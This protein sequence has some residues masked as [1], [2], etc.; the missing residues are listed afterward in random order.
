MRKFKHFGAL[1]LLLILSVMLSACADKQARLGDMET[2]VYNHPS[3]GATLTLPAAWQKL[4]ETDEGAVFVNVDNS[5]SLGL[6]RELAGYSYYSAEGIAELAEELLADT[7]EDMEVL[8]REVLGKPDNAV[9]V[10][11]SGNLPDGAA[12]ANVAVISPLSAVRYFIVVTAESDVYAEQEQVL[13]DIF[14]S[15]ELNKTEDEIY[16]Q[17]PEN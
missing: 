7:L 15:F 14:A 8:Q 17:I 3:N 10:T 6:V 16:E 4:S 12:V 11:A 1:C 9:L 2:V 13:R 5:L